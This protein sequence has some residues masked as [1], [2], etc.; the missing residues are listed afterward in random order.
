MY[1][2]AVEG[3]ALSGFLF[4]KIFGREAHRNL[5]DFMLNALK[6]MGGL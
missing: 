1:A 3:Y 2:K 4:A 6:D 5:A